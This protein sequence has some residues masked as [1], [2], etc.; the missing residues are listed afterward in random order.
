VSNPGPYYN[1]ECA[2]CHHLNIGTA[3]NCSKCGCKLWIL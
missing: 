1:K 2:N 3:P